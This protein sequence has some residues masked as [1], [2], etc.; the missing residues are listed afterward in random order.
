MTQEEKR[1]FEY[2][3]NKSI[4]DKGYQ[5]LSDKSTAYYWYLKGLE[6][7]TKK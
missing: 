3:F 4:K 7:G 5:F 6:Y 1:N 2:L